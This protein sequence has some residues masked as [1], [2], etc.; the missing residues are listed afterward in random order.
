M[1]I[2]LIHFIFLLRLS[3]SS[4]NVLDSKLRKTGL[5]VKWAD[6]FGGQ[7]STSQ[8]VEI[9][10]GEKTNIQEA[11]VSWSDRKRRDRLK[12]KELIAKAK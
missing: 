8:E 3:N 4:I 9:D 10:V 2:A 7:I 11:P 1:H 12:E 5:R 6:H